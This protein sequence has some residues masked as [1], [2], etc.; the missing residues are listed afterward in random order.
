MDILVQYSHQMNDV[1]IILRIESLDAF[2][3]ASQKRIRRN[4]IFAD[5]FE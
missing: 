4:R 2:Y 5:G 3:V 1:V